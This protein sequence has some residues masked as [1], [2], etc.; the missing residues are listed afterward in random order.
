MHFSAKLPKRKDLVDCNEEFSLQAG[1]EREREEKLNF[2]YLHNVFFSSIFF[3]VWNNS[4][5]RIPARMGVEIR[6][7]PPEKWTKGGAKRFEEACS[8]LTRRSFASPLPPVYIYT[9][10]AAADGEAG[11]VWMVSI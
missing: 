7:A 5:A 1:G 11:N 10:A 9:A 2:Y 4:S 6:S 3:T 8:L